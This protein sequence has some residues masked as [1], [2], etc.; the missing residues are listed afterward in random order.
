M[1]VNLFHRHKLETVQQ[2]AQLYIKCVQ[3][4]YSYNGKGSS[5]ILSFVEV[6]KNTEGIK[7]LGL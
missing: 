2:S 1:Y 7:I 3:L 5:G 6:S 4:K